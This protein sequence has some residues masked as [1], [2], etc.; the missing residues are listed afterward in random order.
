MQFYQ[1]NTKF[2]EFLKGTHHRLGENS[3]IKYLPED[4]LEKIMYE[5]YMSVDDNVLISIGSLKL[6]QMK[7]Q[8]YGINIRYLAPVCAFRQGSLEILKWM[9]SLLPNTPLF[10]LEYAAASGDMETIRWII[11]NRQDWCIGFPFDNAAAFNHIEVLE[12]LSNF[13]TIQWFKPIESAADNGSLESIKWITINRPD[14]PCTTDAIDNAAQR[15]HF[16][17]VKWLYN[18]RTEGFTVFAIDMANY[19][20]NYEIA[21][22][23]QERL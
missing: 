10:V 14:I 6:L 16:E 12:Y 20:G 1:E 19:T 3:L 15:G 18:N 9:S 8:K 5:F 4:I 17:I 22:W 23:L 21:S 11:K 2:F 13:D 7:H